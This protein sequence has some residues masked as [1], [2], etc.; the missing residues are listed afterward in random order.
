MT[1]EQIRQLSDWLS[2]AA[3]AGAEI[4]RPGLHLV[5]KRSLGD[6]PTSTVVAPIQAAAPAVLDARTSGLGV[7]RLSCPGNS[8][9]FAPVGSHVTP[10]Q[11]LALLQVGELMLPVRSTQSGQVSEVLEEEGATVGYGHVFLRLSPSAANE[12]NAHA[13]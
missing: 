8:E 13:H 9:A 1:L 11:L 3:L 12:G 4:Q 2:E 7:L 5:L 10:G 6:T